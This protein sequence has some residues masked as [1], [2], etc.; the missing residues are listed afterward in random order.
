MRL[1]GV[2]GVFPTTQ[3]QP[4]RN[5]AEAQ[6]TADAI[7]EIAAIAFRQVFNPIPKHDK[8][9]RARLDLRDVAQLS[10]FADER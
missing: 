8:A 9:R 2:V 10:A 4:D 3:R 1:L 7:H 5:S 6:F